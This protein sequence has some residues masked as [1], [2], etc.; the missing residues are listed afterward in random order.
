M[1]KR[2]Y[3]RKEA[4]ALLSISMDTLDVLRYAG[5]LKGCRIGSRVY[6][7]STDLEQF[8]ATL[9]EEELNC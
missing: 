5:K 7:K 1:D 3:T 2:L 6:I 4:A 8:V 9:K